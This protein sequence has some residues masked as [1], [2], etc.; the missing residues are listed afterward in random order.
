MLDTIRVKLTP[1]AAL[2]TPPDGWMSSRSVKRRMVGKKVEETEGL[3][4]QRERDSLRLGGGGTHVDWAEV[5]LPR[6]MGRASGK[7][8]ICSD[9]DLGQALQCLKN[10]IREISP[11]AHILKFSRADIAFQ[12]KDPDPAHTISTLAYLRHPNVRKSTQWF[13]NESVHWPGE[14][15]HIRVYDA[16]REM[17]RKTG[18]ILRVEA[19]LRGE[20]VN[21]M[22]HKPTMGGLYS[23]LRSAVL[24]L[25]GML[26]VLN[27][28]RFRLPDLLA[29]LEITGTCFPQTDFPLARMF[30]ES[31]SRATRYRL[32]RQ[33][34]DSRVRAALWSWNEVLPVTP[35]P[36]EAWVNIRAA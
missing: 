27:G 31:A 23:L 28:N 16:R 24:P 9:E 15:L 36:A 3:M 2:Q 33:I 18:D 11:E 17:E 12:W 22:E 14:D 10:G 5:S 6:C 7:D 4:Y 19:Q 21:K 25:Q 34:R 35:P 8:Q 30:L 1:S 20:W 26:P 29:V 32:L 13:C